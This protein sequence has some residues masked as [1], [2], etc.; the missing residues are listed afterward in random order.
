VRLSQEHKR[1]IL[2]SFPELEE[3]QDKLGRYYYYFN[4]SGSRRKVIAREFTS[5]GNGYV[6]GKEIPGYRHLADARGWIK[7]KDYSE[8]M[9]KDIVT[10]SIETLKPACA[11]EMSDAANKPTIL[12]RIRA[13][14]QGKDI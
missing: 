9:L 4:G 2:K 10:K 8:K 14:I 12:K 1:D 5:S 7:V 6:Y 3:R 11:Q 13:M